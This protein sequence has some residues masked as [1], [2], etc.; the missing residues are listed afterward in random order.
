M[1]GA[2]RRV[3]GLDQAALRRRRDRRHAARDRR[4]CSDVPEF[5]AR[6]DLADAAAARS[7]TGLRGFRRVWR[8]R[9]RA[10]VHLHLHAASMT[11][12]Y[13]GTPLAK[14]LGI[15]ASCRVALV[16]A[17]AGYEALLD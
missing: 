12:G 2:G 13:S 17:P 10:L 11:T 6:F 14:K 3:D 16:H 9:H 15:K 1:G 4:M 5:L 7:G 8:L